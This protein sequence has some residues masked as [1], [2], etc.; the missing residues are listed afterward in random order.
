VTESFVIAERVVLVVLLCASVF[1]FWW[2][3]RRVASVIRHSR[4]DPNFRAGSLAAR[5]RVFVW[6]VL[7]QGKVI[8]QRPLAGLTHAFVFWGFC[9][10]ALITINHIATG[11]GAPLLTREQGFGRVYFGFVAIF[12]V[13]VAISISYLAARRFIAH[14]IWLG[15]VSVESG[16]VALLIFLLMVTYLAGMYWPDTTAAGHAFWW[17]HTL[18]L[19]A[20]LPLIPHTKHLHLVLSPATVFLKRER[21]SDIP[22]LEG[23]EDFGLLA[24]KDLTCIDSLQ[25]YS[26]VECG[27]CTEHCPAFNTGKV[28]NPKEIILGIRGYLNDSGPRSEE[29]LLAKYVSEEAAF[30]CTTCGGCEFQCP[31]GIQHLPL[32]VGLRRGAVNTGA[33]EDSYGT[34]FFNTLERNGNSL[35][36]AGSERQKFIERAELP[37]FDGSQEYCLWL[38][39]MGAYD[40]AARE[41]ITALAKILRHL[42]ISFGVLRNEKCNGDPA[43]RLG[44]DLLFTTLAEENIENIRTAAPKKILSICPHCV[45]TM[46]TDWREAGH[47]VEIEHH[48]ELLARFRERLPR[49]DEPG[50]RQEKIVFHDPC[51]LGRYRGVYDEPRSVVE[52]YGELVEAPRHRERSFCCGAG[53]G[54]MFLGE[55]K[56]KRINIARAEELV[57]TEPDTVATGCPFCASMFRDALKTVSERPPQLLDIAQIAA[58]GLDGQTEL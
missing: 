49:S 2:R 57:S 29:P 35:G 56:G 48:S 37:I 7:L 54:Q 19:L 10:F 47:T 4:K 21:F 27:R 58:K 9:A 3:F 13:A 36:M 22:K 12:A 5:L 40:P 43:R 53:G 20:F 17:A 41:T 23:D 42:G 1:G 50:A 11:F 31:V 45:R 24:G 33:W 38:G 8:R 16:V 51:Y 15:G 30:Q 55:E 25:A 14:P 18:C 6:E 44:N 52:K 32:I 28:L 34:K 46:S 39:C 26:C